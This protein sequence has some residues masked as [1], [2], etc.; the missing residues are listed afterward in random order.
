M[1]KFSI[2]AVCLLFVLAACEK[3]DRTGLPETE[4]T[5]TTQAVSETTTA[6]ATTT[7]VTGGTSSAMAPED[8]EFVSE[9]GMAGLAEVLMS[10][11][12][13]QKASNAGV[14]AFAQRMVTDHSKTSEELSQFA[15]AKGLAL[16]TELE[17]PPEIALGHLNSLSGAEFDKAYMQH[18]IEDHQNAVAD[19]EKASTNA[20]DLDLRAWAGRTLPALHEHLSLAKEVAGNV[21]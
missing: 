14:K 20:A 9:S 3:D 15:T 19:F 12:A 11:L 18:M 6:S 4:T 5:G 16:P 1:K 21:R 17:G 7:G 8:K 10:N 2:A 13:L